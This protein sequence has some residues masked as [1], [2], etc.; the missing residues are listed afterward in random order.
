MQAIKDELRTIAMNNDLSMEN[1]FVA[2]GNVFYY[3]GKEKILYSLFGQKDRI[4]QINNEIKALLKRYNKMVFSINIT[5]DGWI[6][7]CKIQFK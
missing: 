2:N 1:C 7:L 6:Y 4:M 5:Q 3:D